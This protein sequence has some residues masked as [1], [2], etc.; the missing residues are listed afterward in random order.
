MN[1]TTQD[2]YGRKTEWSSVKELCETLN[3]GHGNGTPATM[4]RTLSDVRWLDPQGL[5]VVRP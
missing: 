3:K 4:V 2:K 5:K 1:V